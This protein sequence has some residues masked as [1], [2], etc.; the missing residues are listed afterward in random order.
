MKKDE[1]KQ[2]R[3]NYKVNKVTRIKMNKKNKKNSNS[4]LE[5]KYLQFIKD[6]RKDE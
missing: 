6:L 5:N 2:S 3:I 1:N 4:I